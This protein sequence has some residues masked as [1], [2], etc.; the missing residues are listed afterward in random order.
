VKYKGT[1]ETSPRV[2]ILDAHHKIEKGRMFLVC[3]NSMSMLQNTRF[4]DHFEFFGD[5]SVHYGI[6]DGCGR[7]IPFE[8]SKALK[9]GLQAGGGCC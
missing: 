7:S 3:G 8:T 1:V 4:K 6:Y 9:A 2:F 5:K